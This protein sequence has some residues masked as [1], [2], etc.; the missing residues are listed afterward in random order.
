MNP[1]LQGIA[2]SIIR[3]LHARKR[4]GDVDFSLGEPTLRPDVRPF[5]AATAWVRDHGCPYTPNAGT[6]ELREL[7]AAYH[8][9]PGMAAAANVCVT[10]GSEEAIYLAI[11]TV[12]DP[13]VDECLVVEPAYLAYPKLAALEGVRTRAV[14]LDADDGFRPDAARVLAALRPET[15][16]VVLASPCNPT[17]RI[18]PEPE[19]RALAAGLAARPGAPVWVLSD[20]VYRELY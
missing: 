4:P 6:T 11:K 14:A 7:I 16:L 19:L 15:R 3:A 1:A 12:L 20:E 17:G 13:A 2:P 5:E 9:F 10:V 18:W 8:G